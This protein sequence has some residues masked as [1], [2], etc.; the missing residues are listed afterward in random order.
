ML[1]IVICK[2]LRIRGNWLTHVYPEDG[3]E[4]GVCISVANIVQYFDTVRWIAERNP[5]SENLTSNPLMFTEG[6]QPDLE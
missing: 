6:L 3:H 5:D 4:S 1:R 2:R